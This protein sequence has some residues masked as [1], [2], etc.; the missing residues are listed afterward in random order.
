[1]PPQPIRI[2]HL[3]DF[4]VGKEPDNNRVLFKPI[5]DLVRARKDAGA[6]PDLV[7][8][9]SDIAYSAQ[10]EQYTTFT[11]EFLYPLA[12][13]LGEQIWQHT[14]VVPGNHDVD[15]TRATLMMRM[16]DRILE[17]VPNLLNPDANGLA[18]RH[19]NLLPRFR[20]FAEAEQPNHNQWLL[21]EH[22]YQAQ[23]VTLH[24]RQIGILCLN[25]A[26]LSG[27][28]HDRHQLSPGLSIAK[29]ALERKDLRE[30]DTLIVLG[31]HPI[32]WFTDGDVSEF[33]ALFGRHHVIYLHGHTHNT[34]LGQEEGAGYDFLSLRAGAAFAAHENEHW[35]GGCSWYELAL[36]ERQLS[37]EPLRWQPARRDW[38]RERGHEHGTALLPERYYDSDSERW[39][40]SL[41]QQASSK[42]PTPRSDGWEL[43]NTTF[44]AQ[45][46]TDSA[47]E[48]I[49]K[50]VLHYFDGGQPDW[51][52]LLAHTA[53]QD[54]APSAPYVP[55]RALARDLKRALEEA[56]QRASVDITMLTGAIGEGKSTVLRQVVCDLARDGDRWTVIWHSDSEQPLL[57]SFLMSLPGSRCYLIV[58]DDAESLVRSVFENAQWLRSANRRNFHFLLCCRDTDWLA[59]KGRDL[60]ERYRD[61]PAALFT[62]KGLVPDDAQAIVWAWQRLG[63]EGLRDLYAEQFDIAQAT[64][65][66]VKEAHSESNATIGAFLGALLRVRFG[67]NLKMHVEQLL[68]KLHERPAPPKPNGNLMDAFAYIAAMHAENQLILSKPVLAEAL[69]CTTGE[70]QAQVIKPLGAEAFMSASRLTLTRHRSIAKAAVEILAEDMLSELGKDTFDD[71]YAELVC[72]AEQLSLDNA[73]RE[74]VEGFR[75]L[76]EALRK[77]GNAPAGIHAARGLLRRWPG[78]LAFLVDL[79]KLYRRDKSPEHSV[80]L[81]RDPERTPYPYDRACYN[82]WA[83]AEGL[84]GRAYLDVWLSG[85]ALAD[86][87]ERNLKLNMAVMALNGLT[88][89]FHRVF[90]DSSQRDQ[91]AIASCGAAAQLARQLDYS[92][93]ISSNDAWKQVSG[94]LETCKEYGIEPLEPAV[95]LQQ[96]ASGIQQAWHHCEEDLP[97]WD[98][99]PQSSRLTFADLERKFVV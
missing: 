50:D 24:N 44:L 29:Q 87:I 59:V 97:S 27:D 94:C 25:T 47:D 78:N 13:E 15:R 31:H 7:C 9:T 83:T 34:V 20:A 12:F 21:A 81:F 73:P 36:P 39:Q 38:L 14:F 10:P 5:I 86:D 6:P 53:S 62:L 69:H 80:R 67:E 4:Q 45:H 54:G 85:V 1:M 63:P 93:R 23:V 40:F 98:W 19:D 76:P 77:G 68:W 61:V 60:L 79:S 65:Q 16:R 17:L 11:E 92:G 46:Q 72:A 32:D 8:I 35:V 82:E 95:A 55:Q 42:D 99:L 75:Q 49:V 22:G 57:K 56:R 89:A 28:K 71:L 26:W 37:A 58:S 51:R 74:Y 84:I 90:I 3:S 52:I 43:I 88:I 2:L 18:E 64:R 48:Q 66:F 91:Q 96:I 33:Y 30:C 70:L 41:G